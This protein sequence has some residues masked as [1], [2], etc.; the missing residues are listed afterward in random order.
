MAVYDKNGRMIKSSFDDNNRI[1]QCQ[2]DY[3]ITDGSSVEEADDRILRELELIN[4]ITLEG[5]PGI[6]NGSW[7]VHDYGLDIP[8]NQEYFVEMP[9]DGLVHLYTFDFSIKPDSDLGSPEEAFDRIYNEFCLIEGIYLVNGILTDYSWSREEYGITSSRKS[10]KS[11]KGESWDSYLSRYTDVIKEF[12]DMCY[13]AALEDGV[14]VSVKDYPHEVFVLLTSSSEEFLEKIR[15]MVGRGSPYKDTNPYSD[16]YN[17]Y[18]CGFLYNDIK[19]FIEHN[20]VVPDDDF[21]LNNS[22]KSIKSGIPFKNRGFNLTG[23]EI[24][25]M[26]WRINSGEIVDYNGWTFVKDDDFGTIVATSPE[27]KT[28][29]GFK[30][31]SGFM[32]LYEY[33]SIKSSRKPIKSV[34]DD[35]TGEEDYETKWEYVDELCDRAIEAMDGD[36]DAMFFNSHL[37]DNGFVIK[38]K[39]ID[40]IEDNHSSWGYGVPNDLWQ[41]VCKSLAMDKLARITKATKRY[42]GQLEVD[43]TGNGLMN[44]LNRNENSLRAVFGK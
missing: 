23:P 15:A 25:D 9:K 32:D 36:R 33:G 12:T 20:T 27:G 5:N 24:Q 37:N 22:R 41:D 44:S 16:S 11:G 31:L 1:Y 21:L 19:Y 42:K 10:I 30:S 3:I 8:E 38:G 2:F 43:W 7:T 40:M 4:G 28:Y 13:D 17:K 6:N 26:E 39:Y 29:D 14:D 18:K 34:R 35:R